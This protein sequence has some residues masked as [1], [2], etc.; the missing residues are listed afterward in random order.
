MDFGSHTVTVTG[1]LVE[2]TFRGELETATVVRL[3]TYVH[4]LF[5]IAGSLQVFCDAR[6]SP[7]PSGPVR[8]ILGEQLA[9][10][11]IHSMAVVLETAMGAAVVHLVHRATQLLHGRAEPLKCFAVEDQARRW[12]TEELQK[13]PIPVSK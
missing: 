5:V 1:R 9:R 12:L 2:V 10:C 6:L 8:K 4:D 7:V 3:M 11:R 13:R